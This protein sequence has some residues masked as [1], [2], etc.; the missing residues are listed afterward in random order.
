MAA[1]VSPK[2]RWATAGADAEEVPN[3]LAVEVA[4]V[5]AVE[6]VE[7]F[8][9]PMKPRGFWKHGTGADSATR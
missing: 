5:Q 6:D 3:G 2:R 4:S 7:N 8:R 9:K 1:S